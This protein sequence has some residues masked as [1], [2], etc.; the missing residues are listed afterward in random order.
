MF[1]M[2]TA[3]ARAIRPAMLR[4]RGQSVKLLGIERVGDG[5]GV[6]VE[7][8]AAARDHDLRA[9][10][11][12]GQRDLDVRG[13]PETDADVL[14]ERANPC[15]RERQR[16]IARRQTGDPIRPVGGASTSGAA[17]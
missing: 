1:G 14:L 11:L 4:E 17:P 9:L 10:R 12:E 13:E 5:C 7:H 16:V 6:A 3:C 8:A 2:Y 15:S